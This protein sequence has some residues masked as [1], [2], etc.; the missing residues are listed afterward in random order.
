MMNI[1][2]KNNQIFITTQYDNALIISPRTPIYNQDIHLPE[3]GYKNYK[4]FLGLCQ[5]FSNKVKEG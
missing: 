1:T 2:L 3:Y 5:K 4:G